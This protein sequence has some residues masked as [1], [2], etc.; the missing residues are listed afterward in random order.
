MRL[1]NITKFKKVKNYKKYIILN[2]LYNY[3]SESLN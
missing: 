3:L 1:L 2:K